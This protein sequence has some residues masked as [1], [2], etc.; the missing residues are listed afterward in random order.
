MHGYCYSD[1]NKA[2]TGDT[3]LSQTSEL[4]TPKHVT[5]TIDPTG[6]LDNSQV[7]MNGRPQ[8]QKQGKDTFLTECYDLTLFMNKFI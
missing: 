2:E 7:Q 4:R 1:F 6:E 3:C 8:P 5:N